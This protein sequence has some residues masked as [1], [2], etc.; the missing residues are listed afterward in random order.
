LHPQRTLTGKSFLVL[1]FQKRTA[2][3][4]LRQS[5]HRSKLGDLQSMQLIPIGI[6]HDSRKVKASSSFLRKRTKKLL[7]IGVRVGSN[8]R[9]NLQKFLLLFQQEALSCLLERFHLVCP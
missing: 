8:A 5:R 9:F 7:L 3:F 4:T 2:C 1:F 6:E